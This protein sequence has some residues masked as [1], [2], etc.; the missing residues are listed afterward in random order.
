GPGRAGQCYTSISKGPERMMTCPEC[1]QSAPDDA[2]FC[3]RCGQGW[4][5]RT[6]APVAG[7]LRPEALNP[8]A[9][10]KGGFEIIELI[11]QSSVENRY[12]AA[13]LRNGVAETFQLRERRGQQAANAA[14]IDA[15]SRHQ[16]ASA[17]DE[18]KEDPAGPRAKTTE[19]KHPGPPANGPVQEPAAAGATTELRE[20]ASSEGA[21]DGEGL[22]S[23]ESSPQVHAQPAESEDAPASSDDLGELFG[24]V[25]ALSMTIKHPAFVR[26]IDGFADRDR[27][28][29][30]YPDE[31][32]APFGR[33]RGA[34]KLQ[35]HQA[36]HAAIQVSQAI[37]YLHR[38]GLRLNDVCTE[39][40][41]LDSEGR[42][43]MSGLDYVTN[44]DE[45]SA[46]P[47]IN[48]G[49]T[50][51]EV[52][53]GRRADKRA[54]VFSASA[55]LYTFLTGERLEIESWRGEAGP[56]RFFPPHVVTPALEQVVRRGL[57]YEPKDRWATIEEF[58]GELVRLSGDMR[59]WSGAYTDVGMVREH[60]EDSI[61]SVEYLRESAVAPA[62]AYLYVVAD[63][64]GGAA[65]GETASAIAVQTAR[66]YVE[67]RLSS[68]GSGAD[69]AALL[70]AALEEANLKIIEHQAA[71]P[72][73]R[74]MGSTAVSLLIAPP[75]AAM[76]WV[77]D[78]R[79]YLYD[80][81]ALRQISKDH[82]L[83][84]R[85]VEIGQISAEEARS[86]E[87]KNV[88]TRSLGARQ[89]GAAGVEAKAL[90]LKR[91]DR[92]VLC[93]DGLTAHVHDGT[94]CEILARHHN[95]YEAAREMVVAANA[96]GGS[97]NISV[98]TVFVN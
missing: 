81:G 92:L 40:L 60:N 16:P 57:L 51:P 30:V 45:I 41:A 90:R 22:V 9:S 1:G 77:G 85:L 3:E 20:T 70:S 93:S 10:L 19:L 25:L 58:K 34:A 5:A 4:S 49:F 63:G 29:L 31:E 6:P 65:A 52:Y 69:L 38:R 86:H 55:L 96:G 14:A 24:R 61:M 79:A 21:A 36:L 54:D 64:M 15:T 44:D 2:R 28:Y 32:L 87:H 48:D 67:P 26:A 23:V 82:S 84:Q 17:T 39:S 13:R 27:V 11:S 50:A 98:I 66:E 72:E 91:G 73:S 80:N 68:G 33:R 8:H 47:V 56:V 18:P 62:R 97:D 88:I 35:E 78:S 83:V 89:S 76:A 74:G 53:R 46:E 71:H 37:S 95:P 94:I 75:N 43:R 42:V 7:R 59:I 12:R